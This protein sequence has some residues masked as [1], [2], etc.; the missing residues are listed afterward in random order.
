[1]PR[2]RGRPL[3]RWCRTPH[4]RSPLH[5]SLQAL[6]HSFLFF[7]ASPVWP[8]SWELRMTHEPGFPSKEK[9][10][11]L[12][13][14]GVGGGGVETFLL[15]LHPLPA[16]PREAA[17]PHTERQTKGRV[18]IIRGDGMQTE[19][20][21]FQSSDLLFSALIISGSFL[22]GLRNVA[23]KDSNAEGGKIWPGKGFIRESW[24]ESLFLFLCLFSGGVLPQG[25]R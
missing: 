23:Q 7:G 20:F 12:W 1:M 18:C 2:P 16:L 14:G 19:A 8:C 13:G 5:S 3:G 6:I 15:H 24:A 17:S 10:L 22:K 25:R 11:R 21:T 4:P 9:Q